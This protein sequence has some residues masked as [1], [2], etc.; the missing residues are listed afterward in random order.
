MIVLRV[1]DRSDGRCLVVGGISLLNMGVDLS[2][3]I[4]SELLKI[5][6][7]VSLAGQLAR[8]G[9]HTRGAI[10]LAIAGCGAKAV[11]CAV[12]VEC[13]HRASVI[14]D[15][16]QDCDTVRRGSPTLHTLIGTDAA[17]AVADL[18]LAEGFRLIEAA[19]GIAGLDLAVRC[20]RDM[21]WGQV[22]D[23]GGILASS[24]PTVD[25]PALLKTGALVGSCFELGGLLVE[26]TDGERSL[27]YRMGRH[28][29]AA[30]QLRNDINNV[31]LDEGR[32]VPAGS[33]I[34]LERNTAVT[35]A[36]GHSSIIPN[37]IGPAEDGLDRAITIVRQYESGHLGE[38][39]AIGS[40]LV[41]PESIRRLLLDSS[42]AID[43]VAD[44]TPLGQS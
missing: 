2:E 27:L 31:E 30:F 29:G 39:R 20:Y 16:I 5:G 18:L 24:D 38:A 34:R 23:I 15:D 42:L 7:N 35:I 1:D 21:S 3:A 14:R 40:T 9:R 26:A 32:C 17:L 41:L 12:A 36:L 33:D 11:D 10:I 6:L 4:E 13:M 8:M 28:L 37:E 44:Q 22:Q 25:G 19:A 43:F